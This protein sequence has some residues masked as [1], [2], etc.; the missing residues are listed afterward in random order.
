MD[1]MNSLHGNERYCRVTAKNNATVIEA[2][3]RL[4]HSFC[5][6]AHSM[7]WGWKGKALAGEINAPGRK[8][9][10]R[11]FTQLVNTALIKEYIFDAPGR[12][13]GP[14]RE[15]EEFFL[16]WDPTVD[17]LPKE[18]R[19]PKL[20]PSSCAFAW[21]ALRICLECEAEWKSGWR[22]PTGKFKGALLIDEAQDIEPLLAI[23][24]GWYALYHH[25]EVVCFGDPNQMLDQDRLMPFLWDQVD[26]VEYFFGTDPNKRRCPMSHAELAAQVLPG[27]VPPAHEWG[28]PSKQ[29]VIIEMSCPDSKKLFT[30][31]GFTIGESRWA[32][33]TCLDYV[34]E[35]VRIALS[36][37]CK[38]PFDALV[39][40]V[41]MLKG[42]EHELVT[43]QLI[44]PYHRKTYL[45]GELQA[46]R[47]LYVALT[48]SMDR[49]VIHSGMLR[50]VRDGA[51]IDFG[52]ARKVA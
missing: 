43:V 37:E 12:K 22:P 7:L 27:L 46:R 33:D 51:G 6:T 17:E 50:L 5:R 36:P 48:R 1:S 49:L 20:L 40:T 21:T 3:A 31:G 18:M 32:V 47:R 24:L 28:N 8:G 9:R 26:E 19:N 15:L 23:A 13:N 34:A 41:F 14:A 35:G 29:G 11:Y 52:A 39:S 42:H 25:L 38:E 45:A 44:K 30:Y 4:E 2:N 10:P 16:A